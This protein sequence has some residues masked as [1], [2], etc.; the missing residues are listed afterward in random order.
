MAGIFPIGKLNSEILKHPMI[1]SHKNHYIFIRI[2]K[3]ASTSIEIELSKICGPKDIITPITFKNDLQ[4]EVDDYKRPL[5]FKRDFRSFGANDWLR[6]ILRKKPVDYRHAHAIQVRKLVGRD[7][8]DQYFK[9]CFVRNPF[10][11]A[12]SLYYWTTKNWRNKHP[13]SLPEIND[14]ILSLPDT[15]LSTWARYTIDNKIAMDFIGRY[16]N[17][18][19]DLVLIEQ[20]IGIPHLVLPHAK[21]SIRK[22]R[23]HYSEILNP[24]ARMYI[25]KVCTLEIAAFGYKWNSF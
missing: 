1:I 6:F 25:E 11:R 22:D 8:W 24:D 12:I 23:S 20:K 14:Y 2:P 18:E 4:N 17:L 16:E 10:D 7:I 13:E 5:K 9:F 21:S 3:T 15:K 19:G